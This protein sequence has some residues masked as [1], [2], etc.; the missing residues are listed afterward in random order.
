MRRIV[1]LSMIALLIG[2][3]SPK[4]K[5]PESAVKNGIVTVYRD[6]GRLHKELSYKDGKLNGLSKVYHPNGK[7]YLETE[8]ANDKRHGLTR[9]YFQ[10]GILYSETYYDSGKITGVLKKYHKD[11]KLKAEMPYKNGVE[12]AG[13][14]EYI[15]NGDPRPHYPEIVI[16][17]DNKIKT[18]GIYYLKFSVSERV[19][20][21]TFYRGRLKDDCLHSELEKIY[22][23]KDDE[24]LLA[25]PVSDFQIIDQ[26]DNFIA[27]IETI[28][29]NV[30]VVE[31][32]YRIKIQPEFLGD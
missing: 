4:K 17:T 15:L 10:S 5:E 12:C 13:L 1:G 27:K 31:K 14:K 21:A 24:A 16:T 7:L 22:Q 9:Q 29:G 32:P 2:C 30:L 26:T 25:Y 3:N 11:G 6:D 18:E 28:A 8:W 23:P 19:H 20:K